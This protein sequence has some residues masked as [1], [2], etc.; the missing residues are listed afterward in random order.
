MSAKSLT[1]RVTSVKLWCHDGL[2]RA[3]NSARQS[4][5]DLATNAKTADAWNMMS[6]IHC[7][8]DSP[9]PGFGLNLFPKAP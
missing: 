3:L 6:A 1:L 7:G 4:L 5:G 8:R 2:K 9:P